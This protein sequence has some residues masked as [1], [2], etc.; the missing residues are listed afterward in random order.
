MA[1]WGNENNEGKE[2]P[3]QTSLESGRLR[4][5]GAQFLATFLHKKGIEQVYGIPGAAILPFYDALRTLDIQ[6][7]NVRHEQTA[8]FMADG[9]AR[10][11]GKVGVCA[12]TSGPGATN[13]LTGLYSAVATKSSPREWP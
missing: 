11:T 9:Y 4:M 8:I 6:S 7:Y 10:A 5:S 2:N 1:L 3:T 13:F 12:A